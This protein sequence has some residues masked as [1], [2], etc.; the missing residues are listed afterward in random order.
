MP[1][2]PCRENNKPGFKFGAQGKCFTYTVGNPTSRNQA[3][4]KANAQGAAI[5]ISQQKAKQQFIID[6]KP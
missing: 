3:R 1:T 2:Q 5:K 6:I 4:N